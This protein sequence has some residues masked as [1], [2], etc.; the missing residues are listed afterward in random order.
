MGTWFEGAKPAPKLQVEA[1]EL[2]L[3][4]HKLKRAGTENHVST[5]FVALEVKAQRVVVP[6]KWLFKYHSIIH[7]L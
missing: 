6:N 3:P 4:A 2:A 5:V 7:L 1:H